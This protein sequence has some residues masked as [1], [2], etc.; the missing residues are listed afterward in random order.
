MKLLSDEFDL[1]FLCT[2]YENMHFHMFRSDDHLSF[3][4]CIVCLCDKSEDIVE[5]WRAI[6][7]MVYVH[8]QPSKGLAAW[9]VYL[10]FVT[11]GGIPT[12]QKYEIEN[13]KFVARKII[14]DSFAEIPSI[15]QL[16]IEL[17]KQLLGS[18]L[19]LNALVNETVELELPL[20]EYFRGAPLDS[21]PESR[22]RR[23]LMINNIIELFNQNEN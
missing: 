20:K 23:T 2:Q 12:W 4:S 17:E 5:H 18:D 11:T 21:K 7:N 22:E 3:I 1:S 15:E 6:Q 14:L 16:G 8:N 19:K 10:V 13:N 9:N